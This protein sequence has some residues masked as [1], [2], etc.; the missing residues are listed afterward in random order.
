M[1]RKRESGENLNACGE[2][3]IRDAANAGSRRALLRLSRRAMGINEKQTI[4]K[5]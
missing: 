1:A 2:D 4:G 5:G 3:L